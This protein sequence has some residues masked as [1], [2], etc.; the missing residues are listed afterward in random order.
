MRQ[1]NIDIELNAIFELIA[2]HPGGVSMSELEQNLL[3]SKLAMSRRTLQRRLEVLLAAKRILVEGGSR[4]TM[5]KS[6]A[7]QAVKAEYPVFNHA[8]RP[9]AP[10]EVNQ[11]TQPYVPLS[12]DGLAVRDLIRQPFMVRKPVGYDRTFLDRYRPNRDFY[13]PEAMRSRL[14]ELGR[15][16]GTIRAAGTYARDILGRLLIDLSWASS[17]LEGNTYSRLDTQRLIEEGLTAQGKNVQETQ[18]ILNH[19]A[20]IEMLVTNAGEIGFDRFTILNLH[21]VLSDNLMADIH[22]SGRLRMRAVEITGTVFL[23]LAMPQQVEECF[24]LLL[25]KAAQITDPFEQ[26]FFGMV[27]LPYLQPFEDVNKRVSRLAANI[28]LIRQNLCPLSFVDVP[29][30]TY[31]EGTLAVYEMNRVELL[32][33]VFAWSYE[34]SCQRYLAI[35]QSL[36]EPDAFRLKY[37]VALQ[38][39]VGAIV[40]KKLPGTAQEILDLARGMVRE[41]DWESFV[42]TIQ[43]E[44][45]YLHEGNIARYQLRRSEYL[46]WPYIRTNIGTNSEK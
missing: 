20:A 19:K 1:Q 42:E 35:R 13:L 6:V 2:A 17:R 15:T 44:L 21:A 39:T 4:A 43:A 24:A 30:R 5:Y 18:M 8:E 11:N 29:D 9:T 14:H 27:H 23:P 45:G 10:L 7:M 12:F 36:G 32:R 25:H 33:D 3:V 38:Q 26:A 22:A 31:I 37:R 16:D 40:R 41:S 28:P 34:R 46:A